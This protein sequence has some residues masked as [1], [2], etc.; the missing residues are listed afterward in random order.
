VAQIIIYCGIGQTSEITNSTIAIAR[1]TSQIKDWAATY[2]P[3]FPLYETKV[4]NGIPFAYLRSFNFWRFELGQVKLGGVK[5][6]RLNL[7]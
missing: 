1:Q 6:W 7:G 3:L 5:L 2:N 4:R